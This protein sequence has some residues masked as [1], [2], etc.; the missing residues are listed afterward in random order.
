MTMAPDRP[1]LD[2]PRFSLAERERRYARVRP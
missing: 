2:V 1:Y